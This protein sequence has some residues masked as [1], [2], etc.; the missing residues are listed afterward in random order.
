MK[1]TYV[2]LEI[3]ILVIDTAALMSQAKFKFKDKD[4]IEVTI[5]L[6]FSSL[7]FIFTVI[8]NMIYISVY[9][10][11]MRLIDCTMYC[12]YYVPLSL[13]LKQFKLQ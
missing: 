10:N 12:L 3:I 7:N 2:S 6:I 13:Q 5:N 11:N 9:D 4:F 1:M 8:I